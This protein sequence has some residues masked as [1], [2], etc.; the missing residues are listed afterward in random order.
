VNIIPNQGK[1]VIV[2]MKVDVA[3]K[4]GVFI[5]NTSDES[6]KVGVV[7][8]THHAKSWLKKKEIVLYSGYDEEDITIKGHEYIILDESKILGKLR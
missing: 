6:N 1:V 2:P 5:P 3:R 7:A 8:Q 4:M